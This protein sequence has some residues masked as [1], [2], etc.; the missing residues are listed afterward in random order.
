VFIL[1]TDVV[2]NLRKKNPHPALVRWMEGIGW[3]HL[4]TTVMTIMEIQ[5]GIE[6]ARQ[7]DAILAEHVEAWLVGILEAG[8]PQMM[9]LD[10]NAA[11]LLGRMRET[12]AL[13]SFLVHEPG[14]KK[15]KPAQISPSQR[16]LSPGKPCRDQQRRRLLDDR[17]LFPAAGLV[18]PF[19]GKMAG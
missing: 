9:V 2:S 16:L 18:Q 14:A 19:C 17:P 13:R 10:T 15:T 1:D 8:K 12:P 7:S 11:I 5:I 4:A 6:G 3:E